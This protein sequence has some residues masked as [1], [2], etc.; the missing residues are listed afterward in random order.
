MERIRKYSSMCVCLGWGYD[1]W[2]ERGRV[3][4]GYGAG[5]G[6]VGRGLGKEADGVGLWG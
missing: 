1:G 3:T 4:S 5:V 6:C 2:V